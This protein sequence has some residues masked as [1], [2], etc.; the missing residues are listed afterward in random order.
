MPHPPGEVLDRLSN[1][2]ISCALRSITQ[3][4]LTITTMVS[5]TAVS[6]RGPVGRFR[7]GPRAPSIITIVSGKTVTAGWS[8]QSIR[9]GN[10][11]TRSHSSTIVSGAPGVHRV[12][13]GIQCTQKTRAPVKQECVGH[14]L[15]GHAEA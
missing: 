13:V 1:C 14:D 15:T 3:G 7:A 6:P 4:G 5:R 8:V 9:A 2:S 10:W 11:R 12:A